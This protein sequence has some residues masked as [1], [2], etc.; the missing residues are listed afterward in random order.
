M[1]WWSRKQNFVYDF[2]VSAKSTDLLFAV[3]GTLLFSSSSY[4]N[5]PQCNFLLKQI[6]LVWFK[7]DP[8]WCR[9]IISEII[10]TVLISLLLLKS[11]VV[12]LKSLLV[13]S[14]VRIV[15]VKGHPV[16]L[17]SEHVGHW[18]TI[19]SLQPGFLKKIL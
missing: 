12:L 14:K 8:Y 15:P 6:Y 11:L 9:F 3:S 18:H 16:G 19:Q 13:V 1:C 5:F 4:L 2:L 17:S 10:S 7:I